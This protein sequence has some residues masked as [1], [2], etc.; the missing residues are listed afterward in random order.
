M[1]DWAL[2]INYLSI[3]LRCRATAEVVTQ[4][5]AV[6]A[7]GLIY[8]YTRLAD[9]LP[10]WQSNR[11]GRCRATAEV[12][13]QS[14]TSVHLDCVLQSAGTLSC[15]IRQKL[16][17]N[18]GRQCIW[19]EFFVR[20][21][22]GLSATL[23]VQS[24]GTLSCNL[25]S[26]CFWTD[27]FVHET[28]GL[29]ATLA[30]QSAGTLSCNLGSQCIWTE[31]FVRETGGLSATLAVNRLRRRAIWEVSASGLSS[32]CVRLADFLPRWQSSRLGRCRA[33]RP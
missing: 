4:I 26:Q 12:V 18:L 27:L 15:K 22:G 10:R 7:S 16:S 29:S 32:S 8:S 30:V 11:L 9:F 6:S 31:F 20:E 24:A 14:G 21:T 33:T 1:V 28:G 5:W 19:T 23:A 2:K 3:Y 17:P 25:G 13:T